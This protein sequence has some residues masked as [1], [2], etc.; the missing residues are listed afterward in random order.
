[1][2]GGWLARAI[3]FAAED[4]SGGEEVLGL[5]G[6]VIFLFVDDLF[7]SRV[8]DHFGAHKAGAEGA[9]ERAVAHGDAV[10]GRLNNGIF[11]CVGTDAFAQITAGRGV[12]GATGAAAIAAVCD[13]ARGAVVAGGD[14]AAVADN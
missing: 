8:D 11:L 12:G 2:G 3:K 1:M 6:E 13:A 7:Y 10:V 4:A 14:D 9:V 5:F